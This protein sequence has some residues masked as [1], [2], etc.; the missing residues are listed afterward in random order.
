MQTLALLH[1]NLTLSGSHKLSYGW[2]VSFHIMQQSDQVAYKLALP[3]TLVGLHPVFHIS[4]LKPYV[5][6]GEDSMDLGAGP[7]PIMVDAQP[8]YKVDN[9]LYEHG[10]GC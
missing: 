10:T 6:G 9:I 5:Q 8:E 4:K 7:G 1:I 3:Q 2:I